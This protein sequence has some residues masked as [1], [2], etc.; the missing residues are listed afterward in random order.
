M[1]PTG[2]ADDKASRASC[3]RSCSFFNFKGERFP[4]SEATEALTR[5]QSSEREIERP[6]STS[7]HPPSA[8]GIAESLRASVQF[9]LR[10]TPLT[11]STLPP[12]KPRPTI[13]RRH[14]HRW[15]GHW[16]CTRRPS[17]L[18]AQKS[19]CGVRWTPSEFGSYCSGLE[20]YLSIRMVQVCSG[21][22]CSGVQVQVFRFDSRGAP[23]VPVVP[24]WCP[25]GA[26]VV[27]PWCT[28]GA[29]VVLS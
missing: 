6:L 4:G 25:R 23:V 19:C 5:S 20:L 15:C 18:G 3:S 7:W 14:R 13:L 10:A 8:M 17:P 28:C 1:D 22:G 2:D 9:R 27:P 11:D 29:P 12:L 16:H 26:P 21:S 24:P